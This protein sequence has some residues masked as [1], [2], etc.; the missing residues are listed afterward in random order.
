MSRHSVEHFGPAQTAAFSATCLIWGSTFLAIRV[1]NEALAPLWSATVRLAAAAVL[2]GIIALLLRAPWPRGV[3]WTGPV[4]YGLTMYG[5]NF[6]LLYWGEQTVPSGIAA[7]LYA[8]SPLSTAAFAAMLRVH[9]LEQEK[10]IAALIGLVGV[11]LIF[12]GEIQ[13]GAPAVPLVLV[14][15]AATTA[16]LGNVLLKRAPVHSTFVVNTIGCAI[17]TVVCGLG[18]LVLHE[19][20]AA[21]REP[22]QWGP[23]LYLVVLGNLGAYGLFTWMVTQWTVSRL[24]LGSL[25]IPVIA[26]ILGGLVRHEAP[27]PGTYL[28]AAVVLLAVAVSIRPGRSREAITGQEK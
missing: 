23:I 27:A 21:P 18:S 6:A 16:S 14:F 4:Q 25:I 17:G 12:S 19:T 22:A 2:N 13:V 5:V 26:V 9:P 24:M 11:C 3:G 1:G 10:L 28:G 15:V 7:V 20:W 8:T